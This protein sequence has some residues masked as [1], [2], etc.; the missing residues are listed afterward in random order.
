MKKNKKAMS[1]IIVMWILLVTWLLALT[2][3]ELIIPFSR[4]VVWM[5]NSSRAYYLANSWIEEWLYRLKIDENLGN[6]K[7]FIPRDFNSLNPDTWINTSWILLN[8]FN[9]NISWSIFDLTNKS[10]IEPIVSK[11]NSEFDKNF[12]KIS[13]WEPIQMDVTWLDL[14]SFEI[15]FKIPIIDNKKYKLK[16]NLNRDKDIYINWQLSGKDWFI[17]WVSERW[18]RSFWRFTRSNT[19]FLFDSSFLNSW[20][21]ILLR[22][23]SWEDKDKNIRN[24]ET[25]KNTICPWINE[26]CILKFSIVN[27][28]KALEEWTSREIT[29]PYLEWQIKSQRS[30]FKL[31][32][33]DLKADWKS[34]WYLR[35]LELK[36]PQ[37]TVN[38]AFDFAVFQ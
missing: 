6:W 22:N 34:Y 29:L 1:L 12:N 16:P 2:L 38:E 13:V 23:L 11:W 20:T 17:N 5:E 4:S 15:I 33:A 26:K 28:L 9:W 25:Y 14:S 10:N 31:R 7:V 24:L 21:W 27:D 36:V 32:Y 3:L 19:D 30:Q 37:T 35:S 8:T 18:T